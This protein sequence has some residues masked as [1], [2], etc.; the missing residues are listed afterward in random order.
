MEGSGQKGA[1]GPLTAGWVRKYRMLI[2]VYA[3]GV[4][5][6]VR[7]FIV[8]HGKEPFVWLSP[9]G[10]VLMEMMD[11]LNPDHPDTDYVKAMHALAK[12]RQDE[13]RVRLD[14]MLDSDAKH[15]EEMLKFHAEYLIASGADV[16]DVNAALNRWHGNFPFTREPLSLRLA[17]GPSSARQATLLEQALAQVPW[18]ADFRLERYVEGEAA[19]WEVKL[20]FRRGHRIDV[21]DVEDAVEMALAS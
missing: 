21:R 16:E 19:R 10:E 14:Q 12:G 15:N 20:L 5:V 4:T 1:A 11:R 7:E 9:D 6:G 17:V 2:V 13:F 8:T 18:V 3:F